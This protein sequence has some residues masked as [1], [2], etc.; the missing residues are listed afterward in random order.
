[1]AANYNNSAWFYDPASKL[2]YGKSL[3]QAQAFLLRSIP[4]KS[5]IL[6]AGGGTGLILAEIAKIHPS[7]LKITYVE[8]APKMMALSKKRNAG[9]NDID[10]IN[11]AIENVDLKNDYDV[12]ITPFLF[13]NFTEENFQKIFAHIHHAL[14]PK[15]LWLNTDFRPTG[16]WWQN[17]LLGSMFWFFRL[18]CGIEAKKL[19]GICAAFDKYGYRAIEQRSFFGDFILSSVY[20]HARI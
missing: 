7:G 2:V 5:K 13:D 9:N 4:A 18:I 19:P 12:I 20:R 11:D 17:I 8:I 6:I 14:K 16:K 3:I 1:M 15:G 10:F